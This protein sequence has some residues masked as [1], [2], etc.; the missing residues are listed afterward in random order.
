M[1]N[2]RIID[3]DADPQNANWLHQEKLS[4]YKRRAANRRWNKLVKKGR[5]RKQ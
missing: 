2:L 3:L 5:S 4:R 1:K